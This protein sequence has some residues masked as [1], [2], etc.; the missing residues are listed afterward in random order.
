MTTPAVLEAP[1]GHHV[2]LQLSK[3]LLL[4]HLLRLPEGTELLG[5]SVEQ[6]RG[7]RLILHLGMASAPEGADEVSP[8]YVKDT[9][10]PDPVRL[11]ALTWLHDGDEVGRTV[12][13]GDGNAA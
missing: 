7:D 11:T 6:W 5:A 10:V 12:L 13:D 3:E 8:H 1:V 4:E 2:I 9:T